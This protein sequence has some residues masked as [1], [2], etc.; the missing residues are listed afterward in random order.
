[1][2]KPNQN[3]SLPLSLPPSTIKKMPT[4]SIS[5]SFHLLPRTQMEETLIQQTILPNNQFQPSS[6]PALNNIETQSV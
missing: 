2:P 3:F 6:H 1:M 5:L 4:N